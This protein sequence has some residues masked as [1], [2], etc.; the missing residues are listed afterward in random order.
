MK[1]LSR[2][3]FNLCSFALLAFALYLNFVKKEE[4]ETPI[5]IEN[6]KTVETTAVQ[7]TQQ[8]QSSKKIMHT[9]ALR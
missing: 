6:T 2:L 3:L 8:S 1:R 5:Q 9:A 4:A 7:K